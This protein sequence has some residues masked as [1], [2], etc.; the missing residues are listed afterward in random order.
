MFEQ[1]IV[2]DSNP[3]NAPLLPLCIFRS[4]GPLHYMWTGKLTRQGKQGNR[5][6]SPKLNK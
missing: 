1:W 2:A 4:I 3:L 5:N 6:I